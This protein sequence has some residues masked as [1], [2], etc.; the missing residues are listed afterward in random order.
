[1]RSLVVVSEEERIP[2]DAPSPLLLTTAPI[3]L[4]DRAKIIL[5]CI[6]SVF[7]AYANVASAAL[8]A[9]MVIGMWGLATGRRI[10]PVAKSAAALIYWTL[11][12]AVVAGSF[13]GKSPLAFFSSEGRV[14]VA[15]ALIAVTVNS[16][17]G[18]GTSRFAMLSFRWVAISGV[19]MIALRFAHI[20]PFSGRNFHGLTSSHHTAGA[21]YCMT[22]I[23]LLCSARRGDR[24]LGL[25][26]FA[27]AFLSGSR[28][29]LL[30][31][32]CVAMILLIGG[33]IKRRLSGGP[34]RSSIVK[35]VLLAVL[36][37]A[38]LARPL[39]DRVTVLFRSQV[40]DAAASAF[41]G[42][43][44]SAHHLGSAS[45]NLVERANI[46]GQ[47]TRRVAASPL[48]GT[49][50]FTT[51]DSCER[52][53][54]LKGFAAVCSSDSKEN[55][56]FGA[57]NVAFALTAE[58]GLVGLALGIRLYRSM[59]A[60]GDARAR[61]LSSTERSLRNGLRLTIV[62]VA[63]ASM[64]SNLALVPA[65]VG[66]LAIALIAVGDDGQLRRLRRAASTA[67]GD[68]T[69]AADGSND[70]F[71]ALDGGR[72]MNPATSARTT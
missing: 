37:L 22:A 35:V 46:W 16:R 34:K 23:A 19:V 56:D 66:P 10:S 48:I 4:A 32:L 62:F 44:T 28:T 55:N 39:L 59:W 42:D 9:A 61:H 60:L 69:I 12:S 53:S 64:V 3:A 70:A 8:G 20:G 45:R 50:A 13:S 67:S 15:L 43:D 5:L 21:L 11:L 54:G 68:P 30:G 31:V 47:S 18:P 36:L 17:G 6:A 33:P 26:S 72:T 2:A 52:F 58:L 71:T 29:A 57:H 7:S 51:N 1:M 63:G 27:P 40:S 24:L 38:T 65:G 41:A 14:F 49:G 25:A